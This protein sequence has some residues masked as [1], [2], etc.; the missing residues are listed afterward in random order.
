[1]DE[2]QSF[3]KGM[4]PNEVAKKLGLSVQSVYKYIQ[5]GS[6]KVKAVPYGKE[7]ITYVIS[8]TAYQEAEKLLK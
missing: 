6:I 7:R 3:P 2:K 1:M 4:S 8:E 5:D